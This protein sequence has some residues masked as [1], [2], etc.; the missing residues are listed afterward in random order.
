M[1]G[2]RVGKGFPGEEWP[3]LAAAMT[4]PRAHPED[5]TGPRSEEG[6]E[7]EEQRVQGLMHF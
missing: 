7:A 4:L 2:V 3:V 6:I 5:S 1:V